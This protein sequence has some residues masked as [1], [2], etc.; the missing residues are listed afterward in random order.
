MENLAKEQGKEKQDVVLIGAKEI[1]KQLDRSFINLHTLVLVYDFPM[2]KENGVWVLNMSEFSDWVKKWG[3]G[4]PF[5]KITSELLYAQKKYFNIMALPE[6]KRKLTGIKEIEKFM[7]KEACDLL[8]L[9][10]DFGFPMV[11]EKGICVLSVDELYKWMDGWN[12]KSHLDISSSKIFPLWMERKAANEPDKFIR[13][14]VNKICDFLKIAPCTFIDYRRDYDTC[15][16]KK[17][18]GTDNQ[19][20]VSKKDWIKFCNYLAV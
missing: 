9:K 2:K 15:P 17:I 18:P 10:R 7:R 8:D 12:I 16:I 3:G 4:L 5:N 11:S 20:E 14:D 13:G 6:E 1:E 19:Y